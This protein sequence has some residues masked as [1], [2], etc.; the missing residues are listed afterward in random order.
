MYLKRLSLA[1]FKSFADPT[2]FLFNRG[3]TVIVGPNGCGKSNVVDAFR[4]VLGERSAKGLRGQ[5]MMDVIFKGTRNRAQLSRAEVSL[6]FDNSDGRL[7]I[8]FQEVEVTRRLYRSGE[9]EYLIN[10]R[11]CRLKDI[12]RLFTDTGIGTEGYSI[13]E[14]GSVDGFLQASAQD[15]RSIFEEA[16]GI[17]RFPRPKE[18]SDP[19]TRAH[20]CQCR[21]PSRRLR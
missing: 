17:S 15:R 4:W 21:A 8:D 14:Q 16:A 9:S 6:C 12:Q 2:D 5:E 13:L 7:P 19:P 20:H 1:G 11:K 18:A 10:K 3:T